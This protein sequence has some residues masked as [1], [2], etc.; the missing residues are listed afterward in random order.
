MC[1]H[2]KLDDSQLIII[3]NLDNNDDIFYPYSYHTA[4]QRQRHC[5]KNSFAYFKFIK[6]KL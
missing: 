1:L 3:A 6:S 5:K 4:Y 2:N